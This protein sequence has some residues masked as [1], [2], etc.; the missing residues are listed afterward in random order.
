MAN[1]TRQDA[2]DFLK[3][4]ADLNIRPK[5]KVFKLEEA[6]EALLAVKL[7][8]QEGSAVIVP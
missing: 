4:A 7:E 6:N 1:M 3:I 2:K 5:V 8:T